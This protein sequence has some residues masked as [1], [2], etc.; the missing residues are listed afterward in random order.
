MLEDLTLETVRERLEIYPDDVSS[1]FI[2]PSAVIQAFHLRPVDLEAKILALYA[3]RKISAFDENGIKLEHLHALLGEEVDLS[4]GYYKFLLSLKNET[5]TEPK[6]EKDFDKKDLF[7]IDLEIEDEVLDESSRERLRIVMQGINLD[8]YGGRYGV[9]IDALEDLP[10]LSFKQ[11]LRLKYVSITKRDGFEADPEDAISL[12]LKAL[13]LDI[14]KYDFKEVEEKKKVRSAEKE[15]A[16]ALDTKQD[17]DVVDLVNIYVKDKDPSLKAVIAKQYDSFISDLAKWTI[18]K[19]PQGLAIGLEDLQQVGREA[20]LKVLDRFDP[21]RGSRLEEYAKRRIVG[22]FQDEL[23]TLDPLGRTTRR[24][25]G[26]IEKARE[27]YT[28][29]H[30]DKP[31]NE[32]L[33]DFMN[34]TDDKLSFLLEK[35]LARSFLPID[36]QYTDGNGQTFSLIDRVNYHSEDLVEIIT[37][38][39][40]LADV[41]KA[42]ETLDTREK[43]VIRMY[44][45]ENLTFKEIGEKF[46]LTESRM[47]QIKKSALRKIRDV[48]GISTRDEI[49]DEEIINEAD[50]EKIEKDDYSYSRDTENLEVLTGDIERNDKDV[51]C[52]SREDDD[53]ANPNSIDIGYE[54]TKSEFIK[55]TEKIIRLKINKKLRPAM[56]SE[57]GKAIIPSEIIQPED[58]LDNMDDTDLGDESDIPDEPIIIESIRNKIVLDSYSALDKSVSKKKKRQEV[59]SKDCLENLTEL[60]PVR[61]TPANILTPFTVRTPEQYIAMMK[62]NLYFPNDYQTKVID[63]AELIYKE[64]G[65]NITA[66]RFRELLLRHSTDLLSD[67][68]VDPEIDRL[69]YVGKTAAILERAGKQRISFSTLETMYLSIPKSARLSYFS[70]SN[71]RYGGTTV[72]EKWGEDCYKKLGIGKIERYEEEIEERQTEQVR[73]KPKKKKAGLETEGDKLEF[74]SV[75]KRRVVKRACWMESKKVDFEKERDVYKALSMLGR[76]WLDGVYYATVSWAKYMAS[77]SGRETREGT[78]LEAKNK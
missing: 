40:Q 43:A 18:L 34:I 72:R 26:V 48:F 67:N 30:K 55:Q 14:K 8:M 13:Y 31:S 20:F 44:Y 49:S 74:R 65:A 21:N 1:N 56:P 76:P 68:E 24:N 32:E 69:Y 29:E 64:L 53:L 19:L 73:L 62:D 45:D 23:R 59:V 47:C 15:T 2:K 5:K 78:L 63:A 54:E 11:F 37:G 50:S 17:L 28:K 77:N 25:I 52:V 3:R 58:D 33:A 36:T 66:A 75:L 42:Y 41:S 6:V 4:G 38:K 51:G 35:R 71:K 12:P 57:L 7:D 60:L 22:A 70:R 39:Q 10:G 9:L 46:G 61:F 16:A 27:N